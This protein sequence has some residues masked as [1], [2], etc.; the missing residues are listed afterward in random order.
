VVAL[1]YDHDIY[2][3][4]KLIY[5]RNIV[6]G[7][8]FLIPFS[9]YAHQEMGVASGFAS[10]F[11]HPLSGLDHLVAMVA[12]GLWGGILGRPAVWLLPVTFPIVMAFGGMLGVQAVPIPYI[13]AGIA[14]SGIVLGIM[15][16]FY[17]KPPLW[18]AAIIV[19]F[20]AIFHGHAHGTELP[21]AANP[22]SYA[23][24]FVIST[25]LLHVSGI[26]IGLLIHVSW[27]KKIVQALGGIIAL[28]GLYFLFL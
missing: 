15:I 17:A 4:Q 16:L 24:G 22:L 28:I 11:L 10:G 18:I 19:G 27:G 8:L 21:D 3:M 9:A 1:N 25:G 13:E 2:T 6:I 5:T 20:F 7:I 23:A 12:V 14:I 26:I